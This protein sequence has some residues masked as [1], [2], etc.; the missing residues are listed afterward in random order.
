ML[1]RYGHELG[2]A[3]QIA[4]DLLDLTATSEQLGKAAGK[5]EGSRKQTHT[6]VVGI[7]ESR[8]LAGAAS[9]RAVAALEP[10]A[11]RAAVLVSLARFVVSRRS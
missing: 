11:D 2:L 9:D 8:K 1:G 3:F 10:F 5:D 7:E 4:D 6:R